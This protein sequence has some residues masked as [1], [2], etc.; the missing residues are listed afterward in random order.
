MEVFVGDFVFDSA[1]FQTH[2]ASA[3]A[4]ALG[5]R[6]IEYRPGLQPKAATVVACTNMA[7]DMAGFIDGAVR[8]ARAAVLVSA[9]CPP[10]E[11]GW[12]RTRMESTAFTLVMSGGVDDG[13]FAVLA[14]E[15]RAGEVAAACMTTFKDMR[16]QFEAKRAIDGSARIERMRANMRAFRGVPRLDPQPMARR[17]TISI[18]GYG[19]SLAD[20]IDDVSKDV[21]TMSGAHDM[22]LESGVTPMW[23]V[24]V[25]PRDHKLDF[26]SKPQPDTTYLISS[27]CSPKLFERLHGQKLFMWHPA[28]GHVERERMAVMEVD[29]GGALMLGGSSVGSRALALAHALGYEEYHLHGLDCSYRDSQ[30]WAGRHGGPRHPTM[31]VECAGKSFTTSTIM[32]NAAEELY[33]LMVGQMSRCKFTVHGDGLFAERMRLPTEARARGWWRPA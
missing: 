7:K 24:E 14:P 15:R 32:L 25:D 27:T 29:G 17:G 5:G 11:F 12:W 13:F 4:S 19:P 30:L 9:I 28:S 8:S 33:D 1:A 3:L 10:E 20:T 31:Q 2:R 18:C 22:L 16:P 21:M 23:H 6:A 26:L